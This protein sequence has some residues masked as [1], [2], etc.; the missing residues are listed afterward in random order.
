MLT[1]TRQSANGYWIE[2]LKKYIYSLEELNFFIFNYIQMVYKEF[3]CEDLFAYIEQELGQTYMAQ[4][5]RNM[6]A[7]GANAEEFIKYILNASFY[8]NSRELAAISNIVSG[9]DDLGKDERM[10]I[11]AEAFYRAGNYNSAIRCCT[12]I[13]EN[14]DKEKLDES[15]YARAAY[16]AGKSYARMF[17]QKSAVAYFAYAYELS[18]EPTYYK[19]CIYMSI[20]SQDDEALL[21]SIVKFK[22]SDDTLDSMRKRIQSLQH[23][24][25]ISE[26]MQLFMQSIESPDMQLQLVQQ[27]KSDY[28]NMLK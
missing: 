1:A 12:D 6:A 15:F 28:Y 5:L 4:D 19:A 10:M 14:M 2:P 26:D 25:E 11:Q 24:I 27:W 20:I 21:E 13:L 23:E 8:Y 18:P 7:E 9:I 17:M 16:T 3:F 22:I